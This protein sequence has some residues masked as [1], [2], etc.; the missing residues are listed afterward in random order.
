MVGRELLQLQKQKL[1]GINV[2]IN[3]E[4]MGCI[5]AEI[6]G[7][8]NTAFEGGVFPIRLLLDADYPNSPPKGARSPMSVPCLQVGLGRFVVV[9]MLDKS[10]QKKDLFEGPWFYLIG[11]QGMISSDVNLFEP[12]IVFLREVS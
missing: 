12:C 1:E 5:E 10:H 4:N 3:E 7:P 2:K 11:L 9:D 6:Y 8:E